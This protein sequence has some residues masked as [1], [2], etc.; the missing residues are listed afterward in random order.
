MNK[1]DIRILKSIYN[2]LLSTTG[3]AEKNLVFANEEQAKR[4]IELS[5]IVLEDF[6]RYLRSEEAEI[7]SREN[8]G[9]D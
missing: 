1:F 9:E 6:D 4:Y 3:E 2:D 8:N 5:K 7:E